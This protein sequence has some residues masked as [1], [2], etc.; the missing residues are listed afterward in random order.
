M[1]AGVMMLIIGFSALAVDCTPSSVQQIAPGVYVRP[2]HEAVLFEQEAIANIGFVIGARSVAVIDSGGS[3]D[4][5]EALNCAISRLTDLPVR[6]VIITH[7]HPDHS[8]G[9]SV[10]SQRGA[11]VVGHVKLARALALRGETYLNRAAEQA[12]HPIDSQTI[13][14]PDR[15]VNDRLELDLGSRLLQ[16]TAHPTAHTDNDLTILDVTTGT[17]WLADL[18]FVDHVPTLDGSINGWLTVLDALTDQ[19]AERAV[20]GHGPVA[21]PWPAAADDL[22]RYLTVVRDQTR[23]LLAEGGTIE[24]AQ[25]QIGIGERQ[26]WQLFD[27]YHRRNVLRAYTELE[28]ED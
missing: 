5:A 19:S 8:L 3:V 23:Q 4:E 10:F 24:Q 2:G 21:V 17:L 14:L 6:Y 20:P 13:V 22:R 7:V 27:E 9:T 15:V 12:G 28:W 25:Q 1:A 18:L 26:Q 11:E 16:I